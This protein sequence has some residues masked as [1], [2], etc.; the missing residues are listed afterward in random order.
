MR[1][2]CGCDGELPQRYSVIWRFPG[3]IAWRLP[4]DG[5]GSQAADRL[6]AS[7]VGEAG[8]EPAKA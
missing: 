5:S 7:V 2:L 3:P 4:G 8:F 6:V 1:D